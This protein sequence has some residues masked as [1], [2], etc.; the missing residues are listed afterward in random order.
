MRPRRPSRQQ[1]SAGTL[2]FEVSSGSWFQPERSIDLPED[3]GIEMTPEAIAQAVEQ[4]VV[5]GLRAAGECKDSILT[6]TGVAEYLQ[7]SPSTI[8]QYV[9]E[10]FIPHIR[11]GKHELRFRKSDVDRWLKQRSVEG[12][13]RRRPA[14]R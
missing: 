9:S 4:D 6:V 13:K 10:E 14:I 3:T 11:I 5:R 12:R 2:P 8:Y 1:Y 7:M